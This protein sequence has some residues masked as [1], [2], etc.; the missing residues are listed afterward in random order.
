MLITG[1]ARKA[2]GMGHMRT[3]SVQF[4]INQ[5]CSHLL[6]KKKKSN[7]KHQQWIEL[8][9]LFSFLLLPYIKFSSCFMKENSHWHFLMFKSRTFLFVIWISLNCLNPFNYF[10][11]DSWGFMVNLCKL[12]I[13]RILVHYL[14]FRAHSFPQLLS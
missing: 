6:L 7:K 2:R 9:D 13:L 8:L 12:F 11:I 1:E 14:L 10:F 4:S 5:N 3:L